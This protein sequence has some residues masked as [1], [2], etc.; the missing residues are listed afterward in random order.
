M[1]E[2]GYIPGGIV[3]GESIWISAENT[4][5]GGE[6]IILADYSPADGYTLAYSFGAAEPITVAAAANGTNTGWTLDVT[7][8]QTLTFGPGRVMYTGLVTHTATSRV[9]AVDQGGI[10]VTASPTLASSWT[11][12]I[13]AIDAAMLTVAS[14]PSSSVSVDGMSVSYR[15]AD[16][17]IRLR[18]YAS[19]QQQRDTGRASAGIIRTR[20]TLNV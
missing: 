7:G 8:A 18:R 20:F 5:Q 1:D 13:A 15:G 2:L 16:D 14:N 4:A 10:K 3:A 6:D 11:A 9:F 17:L 12:L 19:E